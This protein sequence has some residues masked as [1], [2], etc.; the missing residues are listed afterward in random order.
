MIHLLTFTKPDGT[1]IQRLTDNPNRRFVGLNTINEE[2]P[3]WMH[4]TRTG[5]LS[6]TAK[7]AKLSALAR[8]TGGY[9]TENGT[10]QVTNTTEVLEASAIE[11]APLFSGVVEHNTWEGES[12]FWAF[13]NTDKVNQ[14]LQ[15]LEALYRD[16]RIVVNQ[17]EHC[18][19]NIG[20]ASCKYTFVYGTSE[21][22]DK[23]PKIYR[24]NYDLVGR[25]SRRS[26]GFGGGYMGGW[27]QMATT[28]EEA[29]TLIE[30]AITDFTTESKAVYKGMP[31]RD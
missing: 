10:V 13:P 18:T 30:K 16:A 7:G 21:M 29:L 3:D 25:Y 31:F 15:K 28:E 12:W 27:Q 8:R 20:R 1:T 4:R 23:M 11:P 26:K 19:S 2:I 5:N 6:A 14:A 24:A 17:F 22:Y 9:F